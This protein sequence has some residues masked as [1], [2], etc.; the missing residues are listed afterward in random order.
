[1]RKRF[2]EG[3]TTQSFDMK[4]FIILICV[5]AILVNADL[6]TPLD[7]D[8]E[9]D[10]LDFDRRFEYDFDEIEDDPAMPPEDEL[11]LVDEQEEADDL[12]EETAADGGEVK[13]LGGYHS[14][15]NPPTNHWFMKVL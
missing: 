13:E 7:H 5:I 14:S 6:D 1:M 10:D 2:V 12:T 15:K 8:K 11:P 4:V 3:F 9:D